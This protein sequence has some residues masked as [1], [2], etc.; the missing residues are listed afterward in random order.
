MSRKKGNIAEREVAKLLEG[1]WAH[2]EPECKFVR[3]PL[4]GGWGGPQIRVGFKASGDLMTT[5]EKWPWTVE[6]KRREA[7]SWG[8]FI[9]GR[10]SPVWKWWEQ[11]LVQGVEAGLEPML[12]VRQSRKPW[13]VLLRRRD[14]FRRRLLGRVWEFERWKGEAVWREE[15]VMID[16]GVLLNLDAARFVR[17]K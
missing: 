14:A 12:W 4:S 13:A 16:A 9:K 2:V 10:P 11:S 15:P 8:Q 7:W 1:W 3:T 5:A 6:V 17:I